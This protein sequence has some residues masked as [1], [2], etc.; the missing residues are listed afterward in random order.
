MWNW[1]K[2]MIPSVQSA[3]VASRDD[4]MIVE[5]ASRSRDNVQDLSRTDLE[6]IYTGGLCYQLAL[7]MHDMDP[8]RFTMWE[9]TGRLTAEDIVFGSG[10]VGEE[11]SAHWVVK[12]AKTGEFLDAYGAHKT[13]E[14]VLD[15][16]DDFEGV[17]VSYYE[18][19]DRAE[20]ITIMNL[21]FGEPEM[22][23]PVFQT[24][25]RQDAEYT[26]KALELI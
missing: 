22:N 19:T 13:I 12:D 5:V 26:A 7:A 21:S 20:A 24:G 3:T 16:W 10:K 6:N 1:I 4:S 23:I 18:R 11:Y 9:I 15:G 14:S 2:R 17:E 25:W 8:Q